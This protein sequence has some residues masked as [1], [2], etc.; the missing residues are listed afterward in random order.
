MWYFDVSIY[1]EMITTMKLF[2]IYISSCSHYS[3]VQNM[4]ILK[5]I[6]L[7]NSVLLTIV[8]ILHIRTP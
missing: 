1:F 8:I 2:D 5:F 3:F 7:E 6:L 4:A